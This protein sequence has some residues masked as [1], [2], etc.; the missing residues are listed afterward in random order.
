MESPADF[1]IMIEMIK[2][3]YMRNVIFTLKK[4]E[5]LEFFKLILTEYDLDF[6]FNISANIKSDECIL[7]VIDLNND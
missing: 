5:F 2:H 7:K 6:N 3:P 4:E 1:E